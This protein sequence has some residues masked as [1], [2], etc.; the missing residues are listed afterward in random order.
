[1]R[2]PIHE[3]FKI[4]LEGSDQNLIVLDYWFPAEFY[5][6]LSLARFFFYKLSYNILKLELSTLGY[7]STQQYTA[8]FTE[9]SIGPL[10]S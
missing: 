10:T 6:W 4:S 3:I 7:S 9:N 8:G 5:S 2:H 1:M